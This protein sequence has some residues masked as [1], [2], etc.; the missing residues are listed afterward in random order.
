MRT[1]SYFYN[2]FMGGWIKTN[3]G[4]FVQANN[5]FLSYKNWPVKWCWAKNMRI[6]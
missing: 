6:Y 5:N 4:S 1:G 3:V 2:I